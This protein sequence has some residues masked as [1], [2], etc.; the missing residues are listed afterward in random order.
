MTNR[1]ELLAENRDAL[2]FLHDAMRFDFQKPHVIIRAEG[3]FT[4]NSVKKAIA[5]HI[6]GEYS[7]ALLIKRNAA[8]YNAK[9]LY[10]IRVGSARFE[11]EKA[12]HFKHSR[13]IDSFWG[14]GNFEE[15][16][17]KET[18]H[19]YIVAQANE[20]LT[21]IKQAKYH[22]YAER[23]RY[24]EAHEVTRSNH[25]SQIQLMCLDGSAER[26]TFKPFE[27]RWGVKEELPASVWDIVDK[28]GYMVIERRRYLRR[29]A[30][31]LRAERKAAAARAA[32]YSTLEKAVTDKLSTV[33]NEAAALLLRCDSADDCGKIK[34]A[35]YQ[36]RWA[37]MYWET[38][39]N[40]VKEGKYSSIEN[41]ELQLNR[42]LDH[43]SK[44]LDHLNGSAN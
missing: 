9:N 11:I 26:F 22:S 30:Q 42:A 31:D 33:R 24:T 6:R 3:R 39:K 16:R 2:R 34:D 25:I 35:I 4:H 32:D 27:N 15:V 20:Y 21:E 18:E 40:A 44:A 17:K 41:A 36:I 38:H 37:L 10:F 29:R 5:D 8:W 7:A 19:Y 12:Y 28:S 14:V 43:L 1:K 13:N 23:Y